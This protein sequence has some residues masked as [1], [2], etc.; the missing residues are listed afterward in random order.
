MII[1][2]FESNL[3]KKEFFNRIK[4]LNI[5]GVLV[6]KEPHE[7]GEKVIPTGFIVDNVGVILFTTPWNGVWVRLYYDRKNHENAE[8]IINHLELRQSEAYP[9]AVDSPSD[10]VMT[11][12]RKRR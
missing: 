8:E 6:L 1:P 9:L 3:S 10:E 11:I 5:Q 7:D 2:A 12:W 4:K